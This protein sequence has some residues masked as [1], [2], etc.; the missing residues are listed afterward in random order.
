MNDYCGSCSNAALHTDHCYII[1]IVEKGELNL[2]KTLFR[3]EAIIYVS[4]WERINCIVS[5]QI[6]SYIPTT[7]QNMA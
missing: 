5:D 6:V 1:A 2:R 3:K 4:I 7:W